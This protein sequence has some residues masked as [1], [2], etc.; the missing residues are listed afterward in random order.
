MHHLCGRVGQCMLDGYWVHSGAQHHTQE[1]FPCY[2]YSITGHVWSI[3][4][5]HRSANQSAPPD[6]TMPA[7][8]AY[9][10]GS[11]SHSP[12]A[13]LW[14]TL[15]IGSSCS[16]RRANPPRGVSS[17]PIPLLHHNLNHNHP[18]YSPRRNLHIPN[19]TAC[20]P[21]APFSLSLTLFFSPLSPP[22]YPRHQFTSATHEHIL[23]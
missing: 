1:R 10:K 2:S 14:H 20:T 23:K 21:F 3:K 15:T 22:S 16:S 17:Y 8:I 18:L 5:S 4:C 12:W 19:L 11:T 6:R 9:E 13:L 7:A